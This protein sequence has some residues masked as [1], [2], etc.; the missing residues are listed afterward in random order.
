MPHFVVLL[1]G[2]NVGAGNRVP[3]AEFRAALEALGARDVR[4]LLNSGNAVFAST[5]RSPERLAA[6]I[7]DVVAD[8][9]GVR[10]P[11]I[12]KSKAEL[13]AIVQGNPFPPPAA[14][15]ARFLVAFAMDPS[16][17]DALRPV[18]SLQHPGERFAV[19]PH[20]AYLHCVGGLLESEAGAALLG[21]AGRQVT[22]RNWATVLK[23]AALLADGRTPPARSADPPG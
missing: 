8:R 23:L 9:F 11:V 13:D 16:T 2:V 10:T 4:T 15:H 1:R 5:S 6:R 18:A 7:A 3:M 22:T 21:R 12:V 17:L 20:A 14:E 19:T